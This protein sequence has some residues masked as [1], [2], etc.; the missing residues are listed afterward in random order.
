MTRPLARVVC[1]TL[2]ISLGCAHSVRREDADAAPRDGGTCL[3]TITWDEPPLSRS[4]T[5]YTDAVLAGDHDG[6]LFVSTAYLP[7][8]CEDTPCVTV[9]RVPSSGEGSRAARFAFHA[10]SDRVQLFAGTDER[11]AGHFAAALGYR[12]DQLVW[13]EGPSWGD[14]A[15]TLAL[16][17]ERG[18]GAVAFG[19]DAVWVM[20]H[21]WMSENT[22]GEGH[23]YPIHPEVARVDDDGSSTAQSGLDPTEGRLFT[24]A[25]LAPS[26]RGA[27]LV[28]DDF[29]YLEP[30]RAAGAAFRG[31]VRERAGPG[32]RAVVADRSGGIVLADTYAGAVEV[33]RIGPDGTRVPGPVLPESPVEAEL[34][35]ATD[36]ERFVLA[37]RTRDG[38][39]R[40]TILDAALSIVAT[41]AAPSLDGLEPYTRLRVA[42]ASDGTF[43]LLMSPFA[44]GPDERASVPVELR[45]FRACE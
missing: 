4:R 32:R 41:G 20:T 25:T 29:Y 37:H 3:G 45:R 39:V 24:D 18:L 1:V 26:E 38:A 43:A 8:A 19:A 14:A 40:V 42:A 33:A 30:I 10:S 13:G 7:D 34:A 9:E 6:F 44:S 17:P 28:T 36:G 27:W 23:E 12:A 21:G 35:L 2:A 5:R 11:G 15:G 22:I 16:D 31:V